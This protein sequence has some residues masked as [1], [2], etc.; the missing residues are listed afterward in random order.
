MKR[1]HYYAGVCFLVMVGMVFQI[2][3]AGKQNDSVQ[4]QFT[5]AHNRLDE[6]ERY[7]KDV[8]GAPDIL[9]QA[10]AVLRRAESEY[11]LYLQS[12][13]RLTPNNIQSSSPAGHQ[14][15]RYLNGKLLPN[16]PPVAPA[17]DWSKKMDNMLGNIDAMRTGDQA[18]MAKQVEAMRKSLG[19]GQPSSGSQPPSPGEPETLGGKAQ[20]EIEALSGGKQPILSTPGIPG[21]RARGLGESAAFSSAAG[22]K[23]SSPGSQVGDS[24]NNP[25][26]QIVPT[27][28]PAETFDSTTLVMPLYSKDSA[29]AAESSSGLQQTGG[30]GLGAGE[31]ASPGTTVKPGAKDIA[32]GRQTDSAQNQVAKMSSMLDG[33][34][35]YCKGVPEAAHYLAEARRLLKDFDT[36]NKEEMS[37]LNQM[38]GKID[39]MRNSGLV[40]ARTQQPPS[41]PRTSGNNAQPNG[42]SFPNNTVSPPWAELGRPLPMA[43]GVVQPESRPMK[44]PIAKQGVLSPNLSP[45]L[46]EASKSYDLDV[47]QTTASE[48]RNKPLNNLGQPLLLPAV[49]LSGKPI[50]EDNL[51]TL[52]RD[53]KEYQSAEKHLR[54]NAMKEEALTKAL[55]EL[56]GIDN[57]N[58]AEIK[59]WNEAF[60]DKVLKG[61]LSDILS[62]LPMDELLKG[63]KISKDVKQQI[64]VTYNLMQG[65][66]ASQDFNDA[67]LSGDKKDMQKA[68]V[69][70]D[71]ALRAAL[72]EALKQGLNREEKAFLDGVIATAAGIETLRTGDYSNLEKTAATWADYLQAISGP[73]A[74]AGATFKL[75]ERGANSVV[76]QGT[77]AT[78][79]AA[80]MRNWD[81][82]DYLQKKLDYMRQQDAIYKKLQ[83]RHKE[84]SE[85]PK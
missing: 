29:P 72:G 21:G 14:E 83:E 77:L 24:P 25:S 34:E 18:R 64:M 82:R 33:L 32:T 58:Q 78:L 57:T 42:A 54:E 41:P 49:S 4:N 15:L 66:L 39:A 19:D 56:K 76:I 70:M 20:A 48:N 53:D 74:V 45:T 9:N 50:T 36:L 85:Q 73:G 43:D 40:N 61:A 62:A 80:S 44:P 84:L 17:E 51:S 5:D 63:M 65:A 75:V 27:Y 67:A 10:R 22:M 81:G 37:K 7:A 2:L 68:F 31:S 52:A 8:P 28:K 71:T 1:C 47:S 35:S 55:A 30:A 11:Q 6:A 79:N 3:A 38:L 13:S 12:Q 23:H 69:G 26:A 59:Q 16:T 46:G 60:R